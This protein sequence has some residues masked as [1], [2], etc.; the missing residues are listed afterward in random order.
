[1]S[2]GSE[3]ALAT[4]RSFATLTR[5]GQL[6]RLARL[7][8]AAL[9]EFG[10]SETRLSPLRHENN[11][12]F[13]VDAADGSR[14]VLR[15]ERP[16]QYPAEAIDSEMQWLT[17]LRRDTTLG[18]PEPIPT[19][20]G[21]LM[22]QTSATGV[23]D[24]RLVVLFR[25]LDGQFLHNRLAPGH[26]ASVGA[27]MARLHEHA[28]NW[29]PPDGFAR[30]RVDHILLEGRRAGLLTPAEARASSPTDGM[31][32]AET[33]RAIQLVETLC[34]ADDV[35]TVAG[36]SDRVWSTLRELGTSTDGFGLIHADL[37]QANFLFAGDE[38]RAIDFD[39]CGWGHHLFD[40]AISLFEIQ[41]LPRYSALRAALLAGY[42]SVRPLPA[43][44]ERHL[45]AFFALRH[46]QMLF[47]AL[48]ERNHPAFRDR[49]RAWVMD[50]LRHLRVFLVTP[51]TPTAF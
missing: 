37:H 34:S 29:T 16:G 2:T 7:A 43:E 42:R 32:G 13:R 9:V 8:R 15:L 3:Q 45:D 12:T 23:P 41:P 44:W 11:T 25:W 35:A 51:P 10:L 1:M 24:G 36:S 17:A 48:E 28:A 21:A 6:Q 47:W 4:P 14:Y 5:R 33:T 27:F 50:E 18:V 26:L 20:G 30:S 46:L 19:R 39:D 49:W 40:L 38:V 22:V 31:A